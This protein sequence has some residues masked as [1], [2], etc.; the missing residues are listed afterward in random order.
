MTEE[1]NAFFQTE[2]GRLNKLISVLLEQND[3]QKQEIS[4]LKTAI[5]QSN[6]TLPYPETGIWQSINK[7]SYEE[8]GVGQE[9]NTK[10]NDKTV[11]GQMDNTM[12]DHEIGVGHHL[13]T[14]SNA[15]TGVGQ[16]QATMSNY[17]TGVGQT[18]SP[19]PLPD[20]LPTDIITVAKLA[21]F[22]RADGL[23][24]MTTEARYNASKLLIHFHN[25]SHSDYKELRKLTALSQGG[26]SKFMTSLRKRGLIR[27]AGW[28]KYEPTE[29]ALQLMQKALG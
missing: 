23:K 22:L 13:Y 15:K 25:K 27:G 28:Q 12:S 19:K 16:K 4:Y 24:H 17:K 29:H 26:L 9:Q 3:L 11:V 20:T 1:E 5:M 21:S 7:K 18:E 8:T 10:S 2:T 6:I 14:M